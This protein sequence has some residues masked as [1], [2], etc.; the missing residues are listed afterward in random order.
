MDAAADALKWVRKNKAF[1]V[2]EFADPAVYPSEDMPFSF[3]M[4]GS[5]GAGKTEISKELIDIIGESIVRI[6][7]DEIRNLFDGY[8]GAN[9]V[10]FQRA[11][12]AGVN[13]LLDSVIKHRQSFVLDG[14]FHDCN[15]GLDNVNK[16]IDHDRAVVLV[17]VYQEPRVAW[18]FT[19]QREAR[20]GRHVPREVFI[21]R[22]VGS[23]EA[24]NEVMRVHGK[25]KRVRL[26]AIEKDFTTK[27]FKT[28]ERGIGIIDDKL[29][30]RYTKTE[31][32]R[33]I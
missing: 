15:R 16:S 2:Q 3:F 21:E 18:Y 5:P 33:L 29:F 9:A 31:L 13:K 11:A 24:V 8:T 30:Q 17:Y 7:A 19:Q 22:F 28:F 20:E 26:W 4:A 1:L 32:E 14:T 23:R 6:D 27:T 25:T 12:S 10:L